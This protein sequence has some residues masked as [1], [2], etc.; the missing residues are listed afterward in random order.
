[1][2]TLDLLLRDEDNYKQ[3][4][5]WCIRRGAEVSSRLD[6]LLIPFQADGSMKELVGV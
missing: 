5:Y 2:D 3:G 4:L 6:S 1:M